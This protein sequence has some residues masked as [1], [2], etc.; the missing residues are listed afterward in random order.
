MT[1]P[2]VMTSPLLRMDQLTD[3]LGQR[4]AVLEARLAEARDRDAELRAL[5]DGLVEVCDGSEQP[6][7]RFTRGSTG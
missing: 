3:V 1:T 5:A 4:V 7:S 2:S 6:P